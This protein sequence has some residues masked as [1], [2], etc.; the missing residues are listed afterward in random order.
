VGGF[1]TAYRN[2]AEDIDL[3][4]KLRRLGQEIVVANQSRI[5]HHV[6]LSRGPASLNDIR[7]SRMLYTA[8]RKELMRELSTVWRD[9]LAQGPAAY[10]DTL[11]ISLDPSFAATP[12]T[13]WRVAKAILQRQAARWTWLLEG[14]QKPAKNFERLSL[15]ALPAAGCVCGTGLRL[16]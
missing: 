12:L 4:F 13:A 5:R 1:D 11:E 14:G 8:W 10:A 9:L 7:N 6:S 15:N 16:T 3:C 2:G